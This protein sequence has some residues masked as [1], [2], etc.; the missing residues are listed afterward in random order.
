MSYALELAQQQILERLAQAVEG[1]GD[2]PLNYAPPKVAADLAAPLFPLAK[3]R[4][5]NP[6]QLA[7]ELAQQL[8][9]SGTLIAEAQPAGGFLNFRLDPQAFAQQVLEDFRQRGDGYG[10]STAGEG[11]TVVIDYSS[12]N[13][14]KPFSVGHLRSTVI[15]NSLYRIYRFL[16]YR[17]IGDNHIGDWGT[18]FGKLLYAYDRWGS[19]EKVTADPIRELLALYVKYHQVVEEDPSIDQAARDWFRRLESGDEQAQSLWQRFRDL[20]WREFERIYD[21]LDVSFEEVL[22]ESFYN[23]RLDA[24]VAHCFD[25]GLAQWSEIEAR[26]GAEDGPAEAGDSE[27]GNQDAGGPE[28]GD[29]EAGDAGS[30]GP[31]LEKVAV[32]PLDSTGIELPLIIQKSDGTSL[33]ATRDLATIRHRL[34]AFDPERILY[35]VGNEQKLYFEQLF[36]AAE[37]LGWRAQMAHVPFGLIRLPQGKMS[38]RKGRVIFLE[39][40]LDEAVRRAEAVLEDRELPDDEKRAI[41]EAVGIGAVKYAD[42]SQ[43]RTKDVLFDW[44]KMLNL[45]GDSAPYLQYATVRIRSILRKAQK[46]GVA[47][48][49]EGSA[50]PS[51]LASEWQSPQERALL[52][53]LARF[54]AVVRNAADGNTPHVIASHLITVA[55]DF[56]SFYKELS[57]LHA[58]TQ[59]QVAARLELCRF[60]EVVLEQGLH[61]L[62]IRCPQQ[63]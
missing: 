24:I 29:A 4:R 51:D 6:A 21:R 56:S 23:D 1:G 54:P 8:D 20:S 31:G 55:R 15:G 30:A 40:V 27:A 14:A 10:G 28:A 19:E 39:D 25:S 62:G 42:L 7:Q 35:V 53:S 37:L 59:E 60:T 38:T 44:D 47:Q 41:A 58:E 57:V 61:L 13:I 12:P 52:S 43:T 45:Q 22:G 48:E 49:G 63:M 33:Y 11:K 26:G 3:V 9:F 50:S 36:A 32:I 17:V 2:L 18:Q 46:E 5:Q 16:G 34:D